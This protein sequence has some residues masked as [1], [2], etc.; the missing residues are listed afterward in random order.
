MAHRQLLLVGTYTEPILFG[1]GKILQGKGRGIYAYVFDSENLGLKKLSLAE[2]IRNPSYLCFG[3]EGKFVYAV[4]ELKDYGGE[5]SGALSA[6]AFNVAS[7]RFEF[8]NAKPTRGGDPCHVALDGTGKFAAVTNFMT[9][10]VIIY[11]IRED[12]R[13]GEETAYVQHRGSSVDPVR[14]AGPHAH[15]SIF[16]DTNS[17]MYVPDLG[18]DRVIAYSFDEKTGAL[19]ERSDKTMAAA[20]GA[21]PRH[22]EFSRDGTKAYVINELASTVSV[23]S[24]D[25]AAGGFKEIQSVPTLPRGFDD[26]ST[27]ADVHISPSGEYLYA[28]NRGH[29]S[30]AW[31]R[32]DQGTG[33]LEPRGFESTRGRTPRNFSLDESGKF[34]FAA[35]QDSDSIAV[36]EINGTSGKPEFTG[37]TLEVPTPVCLRFLSPDIMGS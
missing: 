7:G 31:Y 19:A 30:I 34:L 32:I 22:L 3:R 26:H 21:G 23:F 27:C 33:L 36:F 24:K 5:I 25:M 18:V 17:F 12:G 37:L 8:L 14:Q 29:D 10:S 35:N 13:L 20:P 1:T 2:G 16:S 9:G 15:S 28:S 4:N 6:F 11:A